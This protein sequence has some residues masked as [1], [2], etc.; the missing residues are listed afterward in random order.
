V[1][2]L[3]T[4]AGEKAAWAAYLAALRQRNKQLWALR[5]ELDARG[6]T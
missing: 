6:L 3:Y 4:R 1:R 5:Q 2:D